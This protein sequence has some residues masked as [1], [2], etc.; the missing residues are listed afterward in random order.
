M[1]AV[2]RSVGAEN[3]ASQETYALYQLS[4]RG[5]PSSRTRTCDLVL[6]REVTRP[7]APA[8]TISS[9]QRPEDLADQP[10]SHRFR[11]PSTTQPRDPRAPVGF[12]PTD[13]VLHAKDSDPAH[14]VYSFPRQ[15]VLPTFPESPHGTHRVLV[16]LEDWSGV[17]GVLETKYLDSF[18]PKALWM[19]ALCASRVTMVS[20]CG[21]IVLPPGSPGPQGPGSLDLDSRPKRRSPPRCDDQVAQVERSL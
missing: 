20:R 10:Y 3:Q 5:E 1:R 13:F 18:A 14:Q 21:S 11:S 17:K 8:S 2:S 7:C 15:V 19:I 16:A 4:Y 6:D 9:F 12:E